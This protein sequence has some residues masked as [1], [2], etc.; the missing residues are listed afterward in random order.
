MIF[1]ELLRFEVGVTRNYEVVPEIAIKF[2]R[3]PL[4]VAR[5]TY[6]VFAVFYQRGE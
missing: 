1:Y 3:F 4:Q 6:S 2:S 5:M